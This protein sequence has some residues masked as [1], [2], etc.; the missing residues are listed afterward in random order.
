MGDRV[1]VLFDDEGVGDLSA[2]QFEITNESTDVIKDVS[3]FLPFPQGTRVFE[4]S[5][6]CVPESLVVL[7]EV[8]SEG[9]VA[10][11]IPYLNPRRGH[12][13]RVSLRAVCSGGVDDTTMLGGGPGW[14]VRH[15]GLLTRDEARKR[16]MGLSVAGILTLLAVVG[17]GFA[18]GWVVDTPWHATPWGVRVV[19]GAV[20]L[21]NSG[22][23][24]A[25][26]RL[27]RR[28]LLL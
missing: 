20:L 28:Y 21:L 10:V 26:F 22:L 16:M 19:F 9:E 8:A 4:V 6:E 13:D 25:P 5:V 24:L 17:L 27:F 12:G 1:K 11:R 15:E 18:G 14:S 2:V 7:T 3:L 23:M